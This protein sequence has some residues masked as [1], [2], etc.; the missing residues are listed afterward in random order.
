MTTQTR[1]RKL[2]GRQSALA[3]QWLPYAM[4]LARQ[5]AA[6]CHAWNLLEDLKGAAHLALCL[7]AKGYDPEA[8]NPKTDRP[9]AFSSYADSA[10]RRALIRMMPDE[11]ERQR[12]CRTCDSLDGWAAAPARTAAEE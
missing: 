3:A 8:I 10:V 11:R 12:R 9:Y 2:D 7:A 6:R 5:H 4:K 1:E